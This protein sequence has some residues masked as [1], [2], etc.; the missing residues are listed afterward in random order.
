MKEA[1]QAMGVGLN[2]IK[3]LV[4]EADTCSNSQWRFGREIINL[5]PKKALRRTLRINLRA[6]TSEYS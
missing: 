2:H 4:H 5:S 1:A 6:I 3:K